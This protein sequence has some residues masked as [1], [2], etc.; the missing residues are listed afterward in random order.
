MGCQ[1]G[2]G[3]FFAPAF[4]IETHILLHIYSGGCVKSVSRYKFAWP[5]FERSFNFRACEKKT[6][7]IARTA[8]A[9]ATEETDFSKNGI[10]LFRV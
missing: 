2:R 5:A 8:C 6:Y 4:F 7:T 9:R 1:R 3:G 10:Q